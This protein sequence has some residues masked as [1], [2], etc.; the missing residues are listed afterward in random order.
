M[1]KSGTCPKCSSTEVKENTYGGLGNVWAGR[2]Y[3]CNECGFSEIWQTKSDWNNVLWLYV[4]AFGIALVPI[5][6]IMN[7]M[8]MF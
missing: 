4:A 6:W 7:D 2:I 3:R 8:G 5:I 1:K